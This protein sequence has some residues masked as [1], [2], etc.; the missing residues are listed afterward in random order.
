MPRSADTH[1]DG[2]GEDAVEAYALARDEVPQAHGV[3]RRDLEPHLREADLE[4]ADLS[5]AIMTEAEVSGANFRG[6]NLVGAEVEGVNFDEAILE[7][8]KF[9]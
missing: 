2:Q 8:A 4:D 1:H 7:D 9:L 6:A 5:D 3:A